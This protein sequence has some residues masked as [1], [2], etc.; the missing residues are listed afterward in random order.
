[1][2]KYAWIAAAVFAAL[3]AAPAVA[4][5][6][7]FQNVPNY[8]VSTSVNS[9]GYNF[10]SN[11]G[12]AFYQSNGTDCLPTCVSDGSRTLLA[13][14]IDFDLGN[15]VTMTRSGGGEF[16]VS[17]LAV[18]GVFTDDLP[19][20]D[21]AQIDY[22]EILNGVVEYS[23][24]INL[25]H[26][27]SGVA[28]FRNVTI[29]GVPVTEIIFTGVNGSNGNDGFSLD[30]IHVTSL[31]EPGSILLVG[32]GMLSLVLALRWRERRTARI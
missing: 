8:T 10:A 18:G 4:S 24:V 28:D 1:M 29:H 2:A 26:N 7:T 5:V 13:G 21:A 9:G 16:D 30:R 3:C 6:I 32:M 14:G 15:Q 23:G 22:T 12:G 31:P 11:R 19:Q 20:Y 27:S 17:S 25:T